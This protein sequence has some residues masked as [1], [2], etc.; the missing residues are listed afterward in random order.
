MIGFSLCFKGMPL[1]AIHDDLVRML[2]NEVVAYSTVT[3]QGKVSTA[4][5]TT[6]DPVHFRPADKAS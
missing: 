5:P 3:R 1:D 6:T 4:S 2:T